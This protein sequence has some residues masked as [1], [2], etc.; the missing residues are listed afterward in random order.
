MNT[1]L[2]VMASVVAAFNEFKQSHLPQIAE[3]AQGLDASTDEVT[4]LLDDA[5]DRMKAMLG[6]NSA[7]EAGELPSDQDNAIE[8]AERWVAEN[9]SNATLED[10]VAAL[11]WIDGVAAGKAALEPFQRQ[12]ARVRLTLDVCYE[13][14]GQA[15][16]AMVD[17]LLRAVERATGNGLLTGD[18]P[19][20]VDEHACT[21]TLCEAP[22]D[23]DDL[24]AFM[25]DRIENGQMRLEDIPGELARLGLMEP[26]EFTREI[27]ERMDSVEWNTN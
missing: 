4:E 1:N 2:P 25:L 5:A 15:P 18:T 8:A 12:L 14:N 19:A 7:N 27:R 13:L 11:L 6:G 24:A 9:I 26:P 20:T 21:V 3:L 23:P 22:L 10:R 16:E 17:H